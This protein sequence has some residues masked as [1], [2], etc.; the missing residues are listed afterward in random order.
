[1]E[2]NSLSQ[3]ELANLINVSFQAINNWLMNVTYP[4][5]QNLLK[6]SEVFHCGV[7]DL[8][9]EASYFDERKRYLSVRQSNLLQIYN[10]DRDAQ[11]MCDAIVKLSKENRLSYYVVRWNELFNG[12]ISEDAKKNQ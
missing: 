4:N 8:T 5:A 9:E 6:L 3:R 1:M 2:V 12:G 11:Q 10:D 7:P